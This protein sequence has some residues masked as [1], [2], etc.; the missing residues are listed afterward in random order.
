MLFLFD[1]F[2]VIFDYILFTSLQIIKILTLTSSSPSPFPLST[3]FTRVTSSPP[4]WLKRRKKF[5][6]N[7]RKFRWDRVQSHIWGRASKK[8]RKWANISPY[9][10]RPLVIYDFAPD[11]SY[12]RK[13]LFYFLSRHPQIARLARYCSLYSNQP[14]LSPSLWLYQSNMQTLM[15]ENIG[16]GPWISLHMYCFSI[17]PPP[18]Q[19]CLSIHSRGLF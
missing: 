5:S 16:I 8:M 2:Y 3:P 13:I 17:P 1:S 10:R 11:P 14:P 7:K 12:M 15:K 9:M 19:S 18:L 6:S 4:H